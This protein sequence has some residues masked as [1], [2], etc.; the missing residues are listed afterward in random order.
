[1]TSRRRG[2]GR[3]IVVAWLLLLALSHLWRRTHPFEPVAQS[4]E[5]VV[6]LSGAPTVRIA[7]I[8]TGQGDS[9]RPAI[10]L[11]HGSPGDNSEVRAMALA[12]A[13][14]HRV[15][16]PDLPGFGGST[17]KIPDYSIRAHADYVVELLDSLRVRRA[18]VVG[19]SM[20]GGVAIEIAGRH[21]ERVASLILLSAI[22]AQEYEL[23]GDYLLNHSL[24]GLQLGAL[25]LLREGVPHFGRWDDGFMTV[26]YARNFYDSDQRP[27]RG[28]L[29]SWPGPALVI[30][31]DKDV[32]VPPAIAAEHGRLMPQAQVELIPGNHFMAFARS[33]EMATRIRSFITTVEAGTATTRVTADPARVARAAEPWDPRSAPR[34]VGFSLAIVLALLALATLVSEDLA[35]IAAGLL[36]GR[37]SIG[38]VPAVIACLV[39]IVLGDLL[40]YLAGRWIGR[41]ALRHAP[42]RW[43]LTEADVTRCSTWF[44]KRGLWLVLASR[45]MPGTRLPTYV[46]AGMLHTRLLPFL[47]AFLVASLLWV[48]LLVGASALF[49]GQLLERFSGTG[50]LAGPAF[51]A[52]LALLYVLVRLG[53]SLLTWRGRRLLLSRWRRITRWEFWPPWVFYPPVVLYILWLGIRH[54]SFTVFTRANPAMPHGGFVGES[55]FQILQD[56]GLDREGKNRVARTVLLAASQSVSE[57]LATLEQFVRREGLT[58]PVVL[59]PDVGERGKGVYFADSL[60]AASAWLLE[61]SHDVLAQERADGREFGVFY[62][63]KPADLAG[64]IFA[65]TDKRFPEVVGDGIHTLEYLILADDRAVCSARSFLRLQAERLAS[66]PAAGERVQ[67]TRL[68]TH[69][70]GALFL[71]GMKF[72]TPQLEAAVDELSRGYRGF[73]FGRY[74]LVAPSEEALRA[75]GPLIILEL[76][77]VTSEATSIYDPGHD[78]IHAYRTLFYQWRIAFE[79]G[80]A[81]RQEK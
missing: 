16:A 29:A 42:L 67:L 49:G 55:K 52:G 80:T 26:E 76:N 17:R 39:G 18:H 9:L 44:E 34:P 81:V 38:F 5:R 79:I 40:L 57:R 11:L 65:I 72:N 35:C 19:F 47:G 37:G 25:W 13:S 74:D 23:L 27:L 41:P 78:L 77:G 56:L 8:D 62:Y 15:I 63:R 71:D 21:P 70:R 28:I 31:G 59:K 4:D 32:L 66:I 53:V 73:Y 12:L 1:M 36:V 46:A 24:H 45:F 3:G 61:N 51:V 50:R 60:E 58:W 68:G 14:T 6:V 33:G 69:S 75:G 22:G 7:T 2:L 30:Q 43:F 10:V 54:R 48:P 20:G 64:H